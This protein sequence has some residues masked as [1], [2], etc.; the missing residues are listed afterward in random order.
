MTQP[1]PEPEALDR[2]VDVA[3]V[4]ELHKAGLLPG[5]AYGA[6]LDLARPARAW[7]VWTSRMLLML[8]AALILAGIIFF[9][10]YNWAKLG[11][12]LKF[13]LIEAA[14]AGAAVGAFYLGKD[15]LSGKVLLLTASVLVGVLLAVYGQAYQTGADAFELFIGWA[16]LSLGFVAIADFAGLW[17]VWLIIL[18]TGMVLYWKQVGDPEHRFGWEALCL[19]LAGVNALALA[20]REFGLTRG[21][22]WLASRW[23]RGVLLAALLIALMVPTVG[24]IV[25][26]EHARGVN[27]LAV[28]LWLSVVI[29]GL[30]VYF[31][32]FPDMVALALVV[33]SLCVI[34][35]IGAGKVL[36]EGTH[37]EVSL[38][39][40]MALIILAVTVTAVLFLRFLA[41]T[42][43][44]RNHA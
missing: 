24:T 40:L 18:E 21:R 10:A 32:L 23:V 34:V 7:W 17:I 6:A 33:C 38:F 13:G 36:F 15:K 29:G 26:P 9:F 41:R 39:F 30:I 11:P 14:L 16:V 8:G 37:D 28:T 25:E 42:L 27:A 43:A 4:R 3:L 20:A 44:E 2:P 12:F 19:T 5:P 35:I 22:E 1:A 31:S